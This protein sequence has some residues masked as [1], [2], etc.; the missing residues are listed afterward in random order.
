MTFPYVYG[1]NLSVSI[2][3]QV[4]DSLSNET[5][6][7]ATLRISLAETPGQPVKL[8]ACD[9][10]GKFETT[11]TQAG[12]YVLSIQSVGK[13][14]AEKEFVIDGNQQQVNLGSSIWPTMPNGWMK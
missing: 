12:K 8:L 14:P 3:G 10:D 2:K 5:V 13:S 11:L 7:Y 9:V 4:V 6:P 1:D